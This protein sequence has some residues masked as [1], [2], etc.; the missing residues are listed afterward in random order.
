MLKLY[1]ATADFSPLNYSQVLAEMPKERA[2][3]VA[4]MDMDLVLGDV[5]FDIPFH[6]YAG[7]DL[8]V[9]GYRHHVLQGNSIKGV[10]GSVH[11]GAAWLCSS[12]FR[13]TTVH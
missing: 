1:H 11:A 9:W 3:W 5:D 10:H 7:K 12:A 13:S 2:E 6:K 8:V 4:W